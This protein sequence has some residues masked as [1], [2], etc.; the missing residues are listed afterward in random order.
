MTR[1]QAKELFL[2]LGF[3]GGWEG[4]ARSHGLGVASAPK[5]VAELQTELQHGMQELLQRHEDGERAHAQQQRRKPE[6]RGRDALR[7]QFAYLVQ[8][9]ERKCLDALV[10]AVERDGRVVGALIHDGLLL[11]RDDGIGR[12]QLEEMQ[13]RR[14]EGAVEA[15]T[16]YKVRLTEKA[17]A[18]VEDVMAPSSSAAAAATAAGDELVVCD[19]TRKMEMS[20]SSTHTLGEKDAGD[21]RT[22]LGVD[23]TCKEWGW[24]E[25]DGG[26]LKLTAIGCQECLVDPTK[27]HRAWTDSCMFVSPRGAVTVC[28]HVHKSRSLGASNGRR[29]WEMF[30]ELMGGME[31]VPKEKE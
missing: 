31:E 29:V 13:L 16:G 21:M 2:T 26:G 25:L 15:A 11:E 4:W 18:V 3:G 17:W 27:R 8:D 30:R 6:K 14:W 28:C 24:E 9:A 23:G 20:V 1:E 5:Y 12:E 10:E 22:M 7:T 19:S